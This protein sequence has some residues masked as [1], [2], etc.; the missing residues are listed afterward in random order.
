MSRMRNTFLDIVVHRV[1]ERVRHDRI[2]TSQSE[3]KKKVA[4]RAPA[5]DFYGA[6][7]SSFGLIAEVKR[8]SPSQ[9]WMLNQKIE[10]VATEYNSHDFVKAISVLTNRDHFGMSIDDLA[11][12]RQLTSKPI[13]RKDFIFD[14]YQVY[15]ARAFGADAILLMANVLKDRS[16][17]AE[18]FGLASDLGMGVLFECRSEDEIKL[19]PP[20][21]RIFG[22]NSRKLSARMFF[23]GLL[24]RYAVARWSKRVGWKND[25]SVEPDIFVLEE[26]IPKGALRVAESGLSPKGIDRLREKHNYNA[27]LIGTAILNDP[28]GATASLNDFSAAAR[29]QSRGSTI[30]SRDGRTVTA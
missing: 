12:I 1:A 16:K 29:R 8:K 15:E 22:I 20:G 11:S 26:S 27:A 7:G 6:I 23:G 9:G 28:R 2:N 21:A 4:D 19:A 5:L 25:Q 3:L 10:Q 17:I 24:N 30:S 18:L 13:L 14:S